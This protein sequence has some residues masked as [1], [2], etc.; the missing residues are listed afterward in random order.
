[1]RVQQAVPEKKTLAL[2]NNKQLQTII[3]KILLGV[4]ILKKQS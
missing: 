3:L 1:M 4:I 2:A